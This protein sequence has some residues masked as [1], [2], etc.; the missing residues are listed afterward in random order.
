MTSAKLIRNYQQRCSANYSLSIGLPK[1]YSYP[2]GNAIRPVPPIQTT[3]HGLMIIGAY[4]SARFERR[5]STVTNKRRLIPIADN[6]QPFGTEV[7]FDGIQVRRLESGAGLKQYVLDPLDLKYE[8]CWITDL[9]K[10]FLYKPEHAASCEDIFPGFKPIVL[11]PSFTKLGTKSISWIRDEI[12]LCEPK[13]IITLGEEVA[14]IVSGSNLTADKLLI[15][16]PFYP[17]TLKGHRTYYC[18]HPDACRRSS[19]WKK[20]MQ[21]IVEEIRGT[22]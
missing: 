1:D 13:I 6:L 9:V 3:T 10:V 16:K 18:P 11:R 19:R 14:K 2:T 8:Q 17:E 12:D 21:E 7:Y 15:P 5:L 22:I 4:P 20:R